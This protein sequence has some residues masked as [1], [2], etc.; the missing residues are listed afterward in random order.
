MSKFVQG[1]G[2]ALLMHSP[3]AMG[4]PMTAE[5]R[6][7]LRLKTQRLEGKHRMYSGESEPNTIERGTEWKTF[8]VW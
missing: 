1:F 3:Y 2:G 6:K 4:G 5:V 7:F 8:H